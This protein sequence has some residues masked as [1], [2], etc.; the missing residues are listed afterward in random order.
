ML[1]GARPDLQVIEVVPGLSLAFR[2]EPF[3]MLFALVAASLWVVNSLYST[4]IHARQSRAAPDGFYVCFAVALGSTVALAFARNLFTLFLFYEALT[5]A[6]YPLVT[7]KLD[8]EAVRG[9]RLYLLLLRVVLLAVS[10]RDHRDLGAGRHSRFYTRRYLGGKAD[11]FLLT[12]LLVL[13]V[14]GIG[15]GR[16]HANAL[17]ASGPPW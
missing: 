11:A 2:V 5:I 13:Y 10:A 8:G 1:A 17:L 16:R 7:H 3:G 9:G 15:K 4:R 14:F 6:T 12:V